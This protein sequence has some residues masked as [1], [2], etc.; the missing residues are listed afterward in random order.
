MHKKQ[1][2]GINIIK[3]YTLSIIISYIYLYGDFMAYANSYTF[4]KLT[5][6]DVK[7]RN[8]KKKQKTK[9]EIK[10]ISKMKETTMTN[11]NQCISKK[12]VNA[13]KSTFLNV[14]VMFRCLYN[15]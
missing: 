8:K 12:I 6:E 3:Y 10:E 13:S 11:T 2:E 4:F 1:I 9:R 15:P 14:H 7:R 5:K